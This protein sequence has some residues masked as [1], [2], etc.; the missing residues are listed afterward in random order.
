MDA[1]SNTASIGELTPHPGAGHRV[2]SGYAAAAL[3][4]MSGCGA[5]IYQVIWI[6]Q[7]SL[8]V[9][10]EVFAITTAISAFFGGLALGGLLFGRWADGPADLSGFTRFSRPVFRSPASQPR[11]R[12]HAPRRCLRHWNRTAAC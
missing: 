2:M 10:V 3:L 4:F 5:L 6:K 12:W 7:L 8:V 9:G 1:R 11:W